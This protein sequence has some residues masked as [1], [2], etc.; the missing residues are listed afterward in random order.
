MLR[1]AASP[2]S[3]QHSAITG[4]DRYALALLARANPVPPGVFSPSLASS[5]SWRSGV[6]PGTGFAWAPPTPQLLWALGPGAF[7]PRLFPGPFLHSPRPVR[8]AALRLRGCVRGRAAPPSQAAVRRLAPSSLRSSPPPGPRGSPRL[9][10]PRP[11]AGFR[12]PWSVAGPVVPGPVLRCPAGSLF[13][14]PCLLRPCPGPAGA[15]PVPPFPVR[16]RGFGPGAPPQRGRFAPA[17]PGLLC[18]SRPRW[19]C[20]AALVSAA[21]PVR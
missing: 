9:Y 7:V 6:P 3:L 12:P 1:S 14:R 13:G 11:C 10:G 16:S 18:A 19:F 4:R 8:P 5:V 20:C 17:S 21:L 2:L 15:P